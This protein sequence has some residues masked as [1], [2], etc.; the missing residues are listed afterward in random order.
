[1]PPLRITIRFKSHASDFHFGRGQRP[2][3]A[4]GARAPARAMQGVLS[5]RIVVVSQTAPGR[6][7][8][9]QTGPSIYDGVGVV[10]QCSF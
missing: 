2:P 3:E 4:E 1:M 8:E 9:R 6:R 10:A 7:A 5:L